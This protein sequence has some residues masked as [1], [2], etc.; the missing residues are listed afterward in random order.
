[1]CTCLSFGQSSLSDRW[2]KA[3]SLV[4]SY[5]QEIKMTEVEL[6]N[7]AIGKLESASITNKS[8][9]KE[10]IIAVE[11]SEGKTF[12]FYHMGAIDIETIKA[13]IYPYTS[14]F[15]VT[16]EVV[17]TK[18]EFDVQYRNALSE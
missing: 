15:N 14:D 9:T 10:G 3:I 11:N 6:N 7:V 8:L 18:Q 13:F 5:N 4:C 2:E 16:K 12:R 17:L 1:M